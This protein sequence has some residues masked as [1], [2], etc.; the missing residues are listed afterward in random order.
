MRTRFCILAA[1]A[2][3]VSSVA[4]ADHDQTTRADTH[5][6]IGVMADHTHQQGEWMFSYRF[7]S[8]P[9]E[10]NLQG[11]DDISP[12]EIVTTVPNRFFGN[13]GQP[14]TLRIVPVEMNMSMHMFGAMYAPND[15][16]TLMAMVNY[17]EKDMDHLT[18][19]GGMGTTVLGEFTTEVSGLGDT[20]VSALVD[21]TRHP[22]HKLHAIAGLSLPTG[23]I[24][25]T[26]DILTPMNMRP[27]IRLPY[28]MQ[29]GSGSWDPIVG[30]N[31]SGFADHWNWGSQWRSTLRIADNDNDYRLGHLHHWTGW[32]GYRLTDAASIAVRVA[33]SDQ[34]EISGR[35]PQIAGPVQTADPDRFGGTRW[36]A[37]ISI[38]LA[39]QGDLDGWRVALEY[40]V[41]FSQDLNGPQLETQDTFTVGIQ[42]S[43]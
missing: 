7:M 41:P 2:L 34:G 31:Y 43:W 18:Y 35:D 14:P 8:M 37:G 32:A 29:L 10:G 11:S 21:F 38:N 17:V 33:F 25:E 26:D 24:D 1:S 27:T 23:S 40:L 4:H 28:P 16:V 19:Q 3:C 42:K 5:A 20:T 9:M 6:P 13:P 39:G 36:D 30:L 12:D 15:R 22:D